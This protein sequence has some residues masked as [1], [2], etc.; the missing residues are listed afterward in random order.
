MNVLGDL[1][2]VMNLSLEG[3]KVITDSF[4]LQENWWWRLA[5]LLSAILIPINVLG[6]VIILR[7]YLL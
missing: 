1:L 3:Q 5:V 4:N 6:L 2:L 7:R